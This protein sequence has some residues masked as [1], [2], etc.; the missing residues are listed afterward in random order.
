MR[1][2]P[3]DVVFLECDV[4]SK[5][6][7]HIKG[8]ESIATNAARMAQV[9]KIMEIPLISTMQVNFGPVDTRVTEHHHDGVKMFEKKTFSMWDDQFDA[10]WKTLGRKSA[11]LYGLEC[12]VCVK[13]TAL[14][15]L[16]RGCDVHLVVDSCS[17]MN[18]ADRAIGLQAMSDAGVTMTSFQS[19]MFEL[20]RRV[21]HPNF[22]PVLN[23]VKQNPERQLDWESWPKL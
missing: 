5:F 12:H 3:K 14:D 18:W 21:D 13:Q 20:M 10:H 2:S 1:A 8:Y 6:A 11:V 23:V 7:K 19:L 17:S 4:Q 16:E 15:L 22:K 9:S